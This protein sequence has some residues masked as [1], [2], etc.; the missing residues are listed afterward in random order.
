MD[1]E[2]IN[3]PLLV[4][5]STPYIDPK[6]ELIRTLELKNNKLKT[7]LHKIQRSIEEKFSI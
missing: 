7:E 5:K 3:A 6:D 2:F 1:N 4:S